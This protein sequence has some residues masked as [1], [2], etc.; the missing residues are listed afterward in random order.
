MQRRNKWIALI[1]FIYFGRQKFQ[2]FFL[3]LVR[4]CLGDLLLPKTFTRVALPLPP[5][6]GS[7]FDSLDLLGLLEIAL[8]GLTGERLSVKL[9]CGRTITIFF[10]GAFADNFFF[11]A[12]TALLKAS[13][14]C[15]RR[16][17]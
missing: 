12:A 16:S 14:S 1:A 17:R 2:N 3:T 5:G 4:S 9:L 6:A 10:L 7:V 15:G 8:D 13:S 11:G